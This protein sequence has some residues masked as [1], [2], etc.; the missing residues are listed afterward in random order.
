MV[1]GEKRCVWLPEARSTATALAK[2]AVL[3]I[4]LLKIGGR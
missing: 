3:D 4:E 2:G 1:E